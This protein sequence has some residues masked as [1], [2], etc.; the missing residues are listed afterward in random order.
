MPSIPGNRKMSVP[1]DQISLRK[2]TCPGKP[3]LHSFDSSCISHSRQKEGQNMAV[4]GGAKSVFRQDGKNT[5]S[6]KL[7]DQKLQGTSHKHPVAVPKS[8]AIG[9]LSHKESKTEGP[10]RKMQPSQ[11]H[12][13]I[14]H[15][16]QNPKLSFWAPGKKTSR[17]PTQPS[18]NP[19]KK[20]RINSTN[21][22]EK[23]H[24]G[25]GSMDTMDSQSPPIANRLGLEGTAEMNK[26]LAAQVP[27][28]DQQLHSRPALVPTKP[29]ME[30]H[31]P[32][33]GHVGGQALRMIFTREGS[34]CWSCRLLT[35]PPP[36]PHDK[37]TP[38]LES[39]AFPKEGEAAGSQAK[40]SVLYEDLWVSSS[41]E[42]SDGE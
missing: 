8:H 7:L 27:S 3:A 40:V 42:D 19:P 33:S 41:S 32:S 29:C 5:S 17:C 2:Q 4:P 23:S 12:P 37:Q 22:P 9:E 11:Q 26:K 31:Q 25:P 36:L 14:H 28:T 6:E 21:A 15:N 18:Q 34:N 35:V 1:P 10:S 13:V 39:P 30:S 38:P 16:R 24:A 20:Q